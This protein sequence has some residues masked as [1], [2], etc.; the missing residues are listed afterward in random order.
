MEVQVIGNNG[1][2]VLEDQVIGLEAPN[3]GNKGLLNIPTKGRGA[4][5]GEEL[6]N[7]QVRMN[8]KKTER[9]ARVREVLGGYSGAELLE[10]LVDAAIQQYDDNQPVNPK[11]LPKN[12]PGGVE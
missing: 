12:H 9:F 3:N 1:N 8:A 6:F 2:T 10:I 7:H 11:L 4:V 5:V